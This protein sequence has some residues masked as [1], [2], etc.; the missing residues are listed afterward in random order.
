VHLEPTS[1]S[2]FS[3]D[4][5]VSGDLEGSTTFAFDP[6]SLAFHGATLHNSGTADWTI[7]NGLGSAPLSF[8]TAFDNMNHFVDRPGSPET[9]IE[10][11][12]RHRALSGIS[13]ANLEYIGS[14]NVALPVPAAELD[15]HGVICP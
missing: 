8:K 10:N 14:F 7:T 11:I 9:L 5:D 6:G 4:G 15:F 3:Y 13:Q 12:G 2:P 1:I